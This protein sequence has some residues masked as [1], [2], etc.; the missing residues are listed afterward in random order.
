MTPERLSDADLERIRERHGC[1]PTGPYY[2]KRWAGFCWSL[3]AHCV[4]GPDGELTWDGRAPG[5]VAVLAL[6]TGRAFAANAWDD[7]GRLLA[8]IEA[9]QI[10]ELELRARIQR[11]EKDGGTLEP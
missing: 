7:V 4:Q 1:A 9:Q 6:E 11:L 10:K 2:A 5:V 3:H 8:H